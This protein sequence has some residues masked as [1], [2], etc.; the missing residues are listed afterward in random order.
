MIIAELGREVMKVQHQ[1]VRNIT[2]TLLV[3]LAGCH[4]QEQAG[5]EAKFKTAAAQVMTLKPIDMP[6]QDAV[7]GAVVSEQQIQ[8]ASRLM[9]YIR[10]ISVHEGDMVKAGQLLFTIDP[11]DIQGQVVQ[12]HSGAAQ[13]DAALADAKAD[14]ERFGNLYKDES[15][16]KAQYD[17]IKLQYNI[18]QNQANAAHAGM[19]VAEAQL[20]YA[21][22]RAPIDGVITQKFANAGDLAAPGRPVLA[23]ENGKK[24]I[25]QT[26]VSD[27][28]YA[29]LKLDDTD[30]VELAGSMQ[31]LP[32]KIVRLVP[33]AD[34]MSHTHLVKVDLPGAKGLYSGAFARV[35]FKTGSK[36][37]LSV[38]KSAVLQRAGIT[39]VFVVDA[40]HIAHYRMVRTGSVNGNTVEISTG[41]NS[42]EQIVV[43]ST[44]ELD[45]GDHIQVSESSAP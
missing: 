38:P 15:I 5:S 7:P 3:L 1:S 31:P 17:K 9:G 8:I 6:V 16:P 40:S 41:L 2:L 35:Q 37:T 34:S 26:A 22:V 10:S 23:M 18:A 42:G 4:P 43:G 20:H 36:Q 29:Q 33:A 32:G 12:A 25:V 11:T 39:G 44:A 30:L 14:Y 21:E 24:L 13:A 19:G 27:E 45:S 28:T